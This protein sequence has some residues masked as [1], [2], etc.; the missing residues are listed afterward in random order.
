M[1]SQAEPVVEVAPRD[2]WKLL[3]DDESARLV[4][5]RSA[6][7]W[8][9]VGGPDLAPLGR[10]PLRLEWQSWP[11]MTPNAGFVDALRAQVE[12]APGP[13]LFLC[14]SGAR[15]LAAARATAAAYAADGVAVACI[16]VAGGFEGD[17]DADDRRGA[18][19]GWKASGLPWRQT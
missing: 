10:A 1:G 14:R 2:A 12:G 17:L 15:S 13:L 4:D 5:V 11:G 8:G 16:N 7:E 9:F 6:P 19:N 3:S 18:V